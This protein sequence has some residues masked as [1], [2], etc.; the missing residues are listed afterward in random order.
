M[1]RCKVDKNGNEKKS[2]VY[3][4]NRIPVKSMLRSNPSGFTVVL[5]GSLGS[6]RVVKLLLWCPYV[7]PNGSLR[8]P[9][10][11]LVS[12]VGP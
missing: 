2:G 1:L 4:E 10:T 11:S 6:P 9:S 3:I 7:V 5:S 12:H 8:Y